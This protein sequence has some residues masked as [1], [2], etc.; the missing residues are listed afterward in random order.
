[1]STSD[2]LSGGLTLVVGGVAYFIG[3]PVT[4]G[5]A[6][7]VGIVFM[8]LAR[9]RRIEEAPEG[10]LSIPPRHDSP[11]PALASTG[12]FNID[13]AARKIPGA[14]IGAREW[15]DLA[16]RFRAIG[17]DTRADWHLETNEQGVTVS[18]NWGLRGTTTEDCAALCTLAGAMLL[19]SPKIAPQLSDTVRTQSDHVWRWLYFLK[20]QRSVVMSNVLHGDGTNFG[21]KYLIF[22][23]SID[24]VAAVSARICTECSA[25]E[26]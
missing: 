17:S 16:D 15:Q 13:F 18:D 6:V 21:V 22:G 11:L 14:P 25:E 12:G 2:L 8:V 10:L 26:L 9:M 5:L 1:M 23:Q 7:L 19:R 24:Q 4:A 20:E 3:G